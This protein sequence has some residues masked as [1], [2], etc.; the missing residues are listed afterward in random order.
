MVNRHQYRRIIAIVSAVFFSAH[1]HLSMAA[2]KGNPS[3]TPTEQRA[4]FGTSPEQLVALDLVRTLMQIESLGPNMVSIS[5]QTATDSFGANLRQTLEMA[6]YSIGANG[7]KQPSKTVDY[8]I[9]E[10]TSTDGIVRTYQVTAGSVK[11]RRD[12]LFT[13]NTAKPLSTIYLQGAEASRIKLNDEIFNLNYDETYDDR[14]VDSATNK[15]STEKTTTLPEIVLNTVT[16]AS[17]YRV[18]DQIFITASSE[19]ETR[20]Y[21]YYQDGHG[22]IVKIFPNRFNTDNLLQTGEKII[23]P[24]TD[25][26]NINAT[27][28]GSSDDFLCVA[29]DPTSQSVISM[30]DQDS[31]LEP[32]A[33]RSLDQIQQEITESSGSAVA[34]KTLSLSTR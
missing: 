19:T 23:I 34:F 31:D 5:M 29:T 25:S 26:W 12:Y 8:S 6:G 16:Q 17:S 20:L 7:S 22:Q 30:L 14:A 24:S 27:R 32:L 2:Q 1:S 9:D 18:G 10:R 15:A 28:I 11:I 13:D 3:N 33:A 4:N 21:C